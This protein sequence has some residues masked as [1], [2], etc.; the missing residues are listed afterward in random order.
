MRETMVSAT[1]KIDELLTKRSQIHKRTASIGADVVLTRINEGA[2]VEQ[3]MINDL[4][5]M[6]CQFT[7]EEQVEILKHIVVDVALNVSPTIKNNTKPSKKD[8]GRRE[9][10]GRDSFFR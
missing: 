3:S 8:S 7:K 1:T 4:S 6:L 9:V 2:V 5:S 10:F